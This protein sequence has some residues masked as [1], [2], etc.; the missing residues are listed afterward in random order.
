[1]AV[2][3][4]VAGLVLAGCGDGRDDATP[5]A[6][7]EGSG[8]YVE[9]LGAAPGAV[10]VGGETPVSE[11]LAENQTGGNLATVGEAMIDAATELNAEA[12]QDPG[13]DAAVELG[14]LVGAAERGAERTEGIHTDLIRR[15]V[16]AARFAPGAE[17]L[18]PAFLAGYREGFDAGRE[19]G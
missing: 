14:Y 1:M 3:G 10:L 16:V 9:A 7:Q 13:G 4:A 12:R 5:V 15:L 17:P 8:A 18:S 2:G 11:C 6:C 19:G